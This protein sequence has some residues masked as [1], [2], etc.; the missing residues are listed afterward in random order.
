MN[1]QEELTFRWEIV[2]DKTK[3]TECFINAMNV[4][5]VKEEIKLD[6]PL[7]LY[8]IKPLKVISK[9]EVYKVFECSTCHITLED[10]SYLTKVAKDP[11]EYWFPGVIHE[12]DY[13]F[14]IN[15]YKESFLDLD[16]MQDYKGSHALLNIMKIAV[17]N[18]FIYIRIDRDGPDYDELDEFDW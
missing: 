5:K 4:E 9:M 14:F 3:E 12:L 13:G 10:N 7:N 8:S 6:Y 11:I 16:E 1:L 2:N 18:D 15:I 17:Q